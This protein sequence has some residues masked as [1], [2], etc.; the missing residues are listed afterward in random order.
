MKKLSFVCFG[1]NQKT[2]F[3][4]IVMDE[5]RRIVDA[6]SDLHDLHAADAFTQSKYQHELVVSECYPNY[7][8]WRNRNRNR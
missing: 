1:H 5:C 7:E 2:T 3:A 4:V 8:A 6:K